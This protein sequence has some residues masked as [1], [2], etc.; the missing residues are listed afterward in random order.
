MKTYVIKDAD[1]NITNPRIK[2]SEEWIKENFD[3]YEEFAPAESGVTEST[4]ARVW[5]NSELERTDLLMLLPDHP[6]KDSLTEYRQ[7]L[8]DWP[9]TSDFPDTQPTI[10]S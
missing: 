5:R 7:K 6:D 3:H 4:M 2:G 9:S 1:G 10:G 8:R